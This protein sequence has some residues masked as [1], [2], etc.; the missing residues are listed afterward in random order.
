MGRVSVNSSLDDHC[1]SRTHLGILALQDPS[2][3][4]TKPFLS[5]GDI[6]YAWMTRLV[7]Q[8][9]DIA[10]NRTVVIMN[11]F[12]LRS[13]LS[14]DLLPAA[15]AFVSNAAWAVNALIPAARILENPL[16][17]PANE[18]RCSLREHGTREQIEALAALNIKSVAETGRAA[19][20]G[21]SSTQLLVF[22]NWSRAEFFGIDFSSV[23]VKQGKK[24]EESCNKVGRPRYIHSNAHFTN[25]FSGRHAFAV[26][27]KDAGGNY[28]FMGTSRTETWQKIEKA[29]ASM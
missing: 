27:G 18:V 10:K 14:K 12:G 28:W 29:L 1:T 13:L 21:D 26:V 2:K 3:S 7:I 22:S 9:I 25:H 6:I 11:A 20:F 5:D 19:T 16:S 24:M 23:V 15:T 4:D 17:Y 8:S